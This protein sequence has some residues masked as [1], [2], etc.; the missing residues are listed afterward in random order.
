MTFPDVQVLIMFILPI[1]IKILGFIYA[2]ILGI[3]VIQDISLLA[4]FDDSRSR[5]VITSDIIAIIFS[6]LNF[7]IF[8]VATR[9][10]FRTPKQMKRQREYKKQTVKMAKITKHKCAIC[11]RTEEEYPDLEFRFCSKCD[12]NYEYCSDHLFT[13]EHVKNS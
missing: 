6:L 8:F 12:G 3:Q 13:H 11:G 4:E 10:N 9:K 5:L 1:K 2:A 7:I